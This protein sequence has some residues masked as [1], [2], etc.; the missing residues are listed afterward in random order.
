M[1]QSV[2]ASSPQLLRTLNARTVLEHAWQT[3]VF[4]ASDVMASVGLTRSTVIGVCDELVDKGWLDELDDAQGTGRKG[5][6]ARRYALRERAGV[7][8]GIDA[9]YDRM[10][11]RVADLRGVSL[12]TAE[13]RIPAR[14]PNSVDRLADADERRRLALETFDRAMAASGVDRSRVLAL[15]LGVPAPVD[16][17]GR[18]PEGQS[19]FWAVMNP[20]FSRAFEDVAPIVTV[21]NDAN[22]AAIAE[23]ATGTG[24]GRDV[25]SYISML[26]GEG[27]GSG[28]MIEGR[29]V[30]GRRGGAGEMRFLDYVDGVGSANGL[31]LLARR[32]ALDALAAGEVD[33]R[34]PLGSVNPQALTESDVAQAAELGD[35]VARGILDRL[36]ERLARICIVLGDLLDVDRVIV[37][38]DL[39]ESLPAVIAG[40]ALR[41]AG[42]GDPTAPELVASRLGGGAV[43]VGAVEHALSLVRER[44][45]VLEPGAR[46]TAE[47][48]PV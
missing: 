18:S 4:T 35:A 39:A 31:A 46:T 7:V 42:S 10:S 45:L 20:D 12:G 37:G 8:V 13:V 40:A 28:L 16:D 11:A 23:R 17:R 41:V 33:A 21:E 6:P 24:Q 26:V 5:R 36:A 44:A 29:L 15:T 3:R 9:G 30:R 14:S 27:I 48:A 38:G 1:A 19:G 25:G 2:I 34:S 32:W 43:S 22:L 47:P